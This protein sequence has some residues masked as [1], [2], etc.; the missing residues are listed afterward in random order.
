MDVLRH[1]SGKDAPETVKEGASLA[2]SRA[3][4]EVSA[5]KTS[6]FAS[7]VYKEIAPHERVRR[8]RARFREP[9]EL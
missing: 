8:D 7:Q 6:S 3:A 9:V 1:V 4:F 2:A 5:L